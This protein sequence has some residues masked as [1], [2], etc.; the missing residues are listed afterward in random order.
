MDFNFYEGLDGI[1]FDFVAEKTSNIK[2]FKFDSCYYFAY[3]VMIFLFIIY[4]VR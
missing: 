2:K 4:K 1:W 3:N